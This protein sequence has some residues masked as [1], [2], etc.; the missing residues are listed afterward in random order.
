MLRASV[1]SKMASR[2]CCRDLTTP[3][4]H[5]RRATRRGPRQPSTASK[6]LPHTHV[7]PTRRKQPRTTI[8]WLWSLAFSSLSGLRRLDKNAVQTPH[9]IMG[10]AS[11][12]R[13][14]GEPS[15]LYRM[16]RPIPQTP[17]ATRTTALGFDVRSAEAM[18]RWWI[19]LLRRPGRHCR[20]PLP[21]RW[22]VWLRAGIKFCSTRPVLGTETRT[23]IGRN[24]I[25]G[26]AD[27][28]SALYHIRTSLLRSNSA[29]SRGLRLGDTQDFAV[30]S[31]RVLV[32]RYP[33]VPLVSTFFNAI[34]LVPPAAPRLAP[35]S[36]IPRSS[37]VS[38]SIQN[39]LR[40]RK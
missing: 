5:S 7:T 30:L 26:N 35:L 22:R 13:S 12:T 31:A 21:G 10:L 27:G 33:T 38:S 1:A 25:H 28:L 17:C 16:L 19:R 18:C 34:V 20:A 32:F 8:F 4:H 36:R 3:S 40:G 29:G 15:R 11:P 37:R 14:L 24:L 39:A 23:G 2:P 6:H 9:C